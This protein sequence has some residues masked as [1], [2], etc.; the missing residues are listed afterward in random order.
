MSG[1]GVL[2]IEVLNLTL[3]SKASALQREISTALRRESVITKGG[4]VNPLEAA[5]WGEESLVRC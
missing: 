2:V 4:A 3:K 5:R 1:G